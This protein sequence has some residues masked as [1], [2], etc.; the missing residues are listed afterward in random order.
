M[1]DLLLLDQYDLIQNKISLVIHWHTIQCICKIQIEWLVTWQLSHLSDSYYFPLK[2]NDNHLVECSLS[3]I[4]F[5]VLV[6]SAIYRLWIFV[7][8]KYNCNRFPCFCQ[9]SLRKSNKRS[10]F[11]SAF[12]FDVNNKFTSQW[13][14][15]IHL[16]YKFAFHNHMPKWKF[17]ILRKQ[18]NGLFI[19]P[20][21]KNEI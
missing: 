2:H 17:N 5:T 9:W 18:F 19:F 20:W 13:Q 7:F 8:Y 15:E 3:S 1:L 14:R 10:K 12:C 11:T 6:Y 4:E 21:K 16:Q